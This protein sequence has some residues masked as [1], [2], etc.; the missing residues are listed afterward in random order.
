MLDEIKNNQYTRYVIGIIIVFII[1]F[2][3]TIKPSKVEEISLYKDKILMLQKE[4]IDLNKKDSLNIKILKETQLKVT[5]LEIDNEKFKKE[6]W[7]KAEFFENGNIKNEEIR[8]VENLTNVKIRYKIRD[9]VYIRDSIVVQINKIDSIVVKEKIVEKVVEKLDKKIISNF[10][11]FEI[12]VSVGEAYKLPGFTTIGNI[13][14]TYN[15]NNMLFINTNYKNNNIIDFELNNG[16]VS[17]NIGL[18]I[19]L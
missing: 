16:S 11:K 18:K 9:S 14:F 8:T 10:K 17:G 1:G 13:D 4:N 12:S 5:N 15:I 6:Y 2:L 19:N 3:T 7:Y